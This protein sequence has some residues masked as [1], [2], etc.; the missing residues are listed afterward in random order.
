MKVGS[1]GGVLPLFRFIN[2]GWEE[3]ELEKSENKK[4][5]R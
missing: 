4:C 3:I 5:C 1:A 2:P